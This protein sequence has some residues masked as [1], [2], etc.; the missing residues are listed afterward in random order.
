MSQYGFLCL[1]EQEPILSQVEI[2]VNFIPLKRLRK[3]SLWQ[4]GCYP[5]SS[6]LN[7][8]PAG[9]SPASTEPPME[10]D[11]KPC[12]PL[13]S[14][15]PQ[16]KPFSVLPRA[17]FTCRPDGA[18]SPAWLKKRAVLPPWNGLRKLP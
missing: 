18:G 9:R 11:G 6:V 10:A 5:C 14:G 1:A 13:I 12:W 3:Q 16:K 4:N 7:S 17:N 2:F 8:C 15:L